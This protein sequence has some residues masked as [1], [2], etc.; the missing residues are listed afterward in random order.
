M[1]GFLARRITQ[2]VVVLLAIS[3]ATFLIVRLAPGGPEYVLADVNLLSDEQLTAIR[4]QLGLEEPLHIQYFETITSLFSGELRSFRTGQTTVEIILD[5]LPVS[6][7]L[8]ALT[9]VIAVVLGIAL[10]VFSAVFPYTKKDEFLT[11]LALLALS[12]PQFWLGLMA[13]VVFSVNLKWL[14]ASG[15]GPIGSSPDFLT[16]AKHMILPTLVLSANTVAWMSR[17]TR[18]SMLENLAQDYV[19][20]AR[21]K[22]LRGSRVLLVHALKNSLI[23]VISLVGLLVPILISATVVVE[24]VFGLPGM[25]RAIVTAALE[26][27]YPV[28]FATNIVA[29]VLVLG[30]NLLVDI[31]YMVVDPRIELKV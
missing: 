1:V 8:I 3:I 12:I 4:A 26:R 13:I 2:S 6:L 25:G 29:A 21:A 31:L 17:Y 10:G 19:R 24:T 16:M 22:G 23:T 28:V 15:L 27:D 5:A 30:T 18:S 11:T 14:P 7:L 20:A 9:I